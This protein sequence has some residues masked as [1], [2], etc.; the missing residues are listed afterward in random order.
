MKN[1][2]IL[3]WE[4][5]GYED[6]QGRKVR[7]TTKDATINNRLTVL[8]SMLTYACEATPVVLE[9]MPCRIRMRAVDRAGREVAFYDVETY[10]RLVAA[11]ARLDRRMLCVVLLAGDGG[12][13]RNE[14]IAVNLDDV[15][16][17]RGEITVLSRP[18]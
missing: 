11:A 15:D 3:K 12:L 17:A 5:G 10:E 9:K 6:R 8:S 1:E 16:F 2:L 14:V 18:D 13:R 4:K 7:P